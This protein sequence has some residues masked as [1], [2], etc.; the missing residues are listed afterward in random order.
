MMR[1]AAA[2]PSRLT[3]KPVTTSAPTPQSAPPGGNGA[4]HGL[5]VAIEPDS[6]P[7]DRPH[8]G[9]PCL[10]CPVYSQ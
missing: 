3:I 4:E 5:P 1:A 2:A 8:H 6:R 9:N 10:T 7:R